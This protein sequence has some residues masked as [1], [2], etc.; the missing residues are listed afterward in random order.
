MKQ[1]A[2]MCP[3]GDKIIGISKYALALALLWS[4]FQNYFVLA[5]VSHTPFCGKCHS[6]MGVVG[7]ADG[8]GQSVA[9]LLLLIHMPLMPIYLP[10]QFCD[11][12]VE[13]T[14]Q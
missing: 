4:L 2:T 7:L 3:P 11:L 6:Y 9:Q 14:V 13:G 5:T 12:V 1:A 8:S 10:K